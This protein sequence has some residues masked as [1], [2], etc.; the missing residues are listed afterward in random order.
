MKK[1]KAVIKTEDVKK[2]DLFEV[3]YMNRWQLAWRVLRRHKLGMISLWI[4]IIMYLVAIFAD[5]LSP[6]DPYEQWQGLSYSPP[7]NIHWKDEDGKFTR[8]MFIPTF[9]KGIQ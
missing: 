1:Q 8:P 7:S 6:H 5:F 9:S 4:L 3:E 2:D